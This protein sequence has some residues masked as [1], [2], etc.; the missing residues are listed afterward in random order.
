MEWAQVE[1]GRL[2]TGQRTQ[3]QESR[4]SYEWASMWIPHKHSI[5]I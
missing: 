4:E 1:E 5:P 3:L 2:S